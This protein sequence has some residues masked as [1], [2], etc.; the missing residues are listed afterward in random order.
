MKI[1]KNHRG[2][3]QTPSRDTCGPRSSG[4]FGGI[5]RPFA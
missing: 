4:Y 1:P 5:T 3:H 2:S